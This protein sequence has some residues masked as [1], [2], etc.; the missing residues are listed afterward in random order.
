MTGWSGGAWSF[1]HLGC[2]GAP[3][4][5]CGHG[6]AHSNVEKT[7]IIAEKPYIIESNDKY[8]LVVPK[9]ESNK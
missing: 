8:T 9:Y 3:K 2:K 1:V 7:P 6:A 5:Y 4:S